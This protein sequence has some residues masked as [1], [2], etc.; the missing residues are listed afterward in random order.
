MSASE[1]ILVNATEMN[2]GQDRGFAVVRPD[3]QISSIP[4]CDSSRLAGHARRLW[5]ALAIKPRG[6]PTTMAIFPNDLKDSQQRLSSVQSCSMHG[7]RWNTT[8]DT[9]RWPQSHLPS[10]DALCH[11]QACSKLLTGNFRPFRSRMSDDAK[12]TAAPCNSA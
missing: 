3:L 9:D 6:R 7:Q 5:T 11:W 12:R 1:F 2:C 10:A 8:F 4:T